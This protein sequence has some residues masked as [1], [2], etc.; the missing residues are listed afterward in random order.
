MITC[1]HKNFIHYKSYESR[2]EQIDY[3][4]STPMKVKP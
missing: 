1:T 3:V 2:N 4:S